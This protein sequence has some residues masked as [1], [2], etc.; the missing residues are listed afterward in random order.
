MKKSVWK[1]LAGMGLVLM[2]SA[3][4]L[5]GCGG[6]K[7]EGGAA[8]SASNGAAA[9]AGTLAKIKERDKFVVGVK[10]DLN[11]FGL[12]DPSTGNVEGFDIDIAKAIAKKCSVTKTKSS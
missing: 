1:K 2:L 3:T 5:A 7:T 8:G 11:L 6:G 9:G 10:Y 4:A 12:K